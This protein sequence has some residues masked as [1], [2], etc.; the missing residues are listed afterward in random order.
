MTFYFI[1]DYKMMDV[2][3]V[4]VMTMMKMMTTMAIMIMMAIV[5]GLYF[6]QCQYSQ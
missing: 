4:V 5:S 2:T 3:V 6:L 1:F